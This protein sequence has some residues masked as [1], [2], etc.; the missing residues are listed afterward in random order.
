MN[1]YTAHATPEETVTFF[2]VWMLRQLGDAATN[3]NNLKARNAAE[4][5]IFDDVEYWSNIDCERLY[6][7]ACERAKIQPYTR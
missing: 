6:L 5:L 7:Y 2:E 4:D 3:E 1:A